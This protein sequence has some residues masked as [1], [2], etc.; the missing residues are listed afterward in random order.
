LQI[1]GE[2]TPTSVGS[3]ICVLYWRRMA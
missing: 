3:S 2:I 1:R